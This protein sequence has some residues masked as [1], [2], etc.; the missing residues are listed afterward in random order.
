[1]G[2][3]EA[4]QGTGDKDRRWTTTVTKMEKW[5]TETQAAGKGREESRAVQRVR[6]PRRA[7]MRNG[8]ELGG[9][10]AARPLG[11]R[12]ESK[13]GRETKPPTPDTRASRRGRSLATCG[14]GAGGRPQ[15]IMNEQPL[16][17]GPQGAGGDPCSGEGKAPRGPQWIRPRLLPGGAHA[18]TCTTLSVLLLLTGSRCRPTLPW[19]PHTA[20]AQADR[21]WQAPRW[22]HAGPREPAGRGSVGPQRELYPCPTVSPG[23]PSPRASLL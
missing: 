4:G 7:L 3:R 1:M 11:A 22:P 21:A 16:L 10:S 19:A 20:P 15:K 13:P 17:G 8:P 23:E 5:G 12:A 18:P 6:V 9:G 14:T 2:L